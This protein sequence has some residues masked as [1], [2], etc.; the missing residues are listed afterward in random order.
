MQNIEYVVRRRRAPGFTL[1]ELM[2]TVAIVGILAA[3]A[4]PA[5]QNYIK[6]GRRVDAKS[7]L[8]ELA[9]REERYFATNNTYTATVTD[10]NYTKIGVG[11]STFNAGSTSMVYYTVQITAA[12]AT[13]WAATA[14]RTTAGA[15]NTDVCG[16][17]SIDNLGQQT[18]A[19]GTQT[20]GCW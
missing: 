9:A 2:I 13:A 10:L 20:T 19:N 6:K 4:I 7:A 15:Q 8:L 1:I 18:V 3:V 11:T 12:S 16:D 5:Y 17:Y 14:T